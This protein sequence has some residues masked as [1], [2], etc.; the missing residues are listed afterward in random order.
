MNGTWVK[1]T[2]LCFWM[3]F[4]SQALHF[5]ILPVQFEAMR[6][7]PAWRACGSSLF[8]IICMVVNAALV[9]CMSA[10][11]PDTTNMFVGIFVFSILLFALISWQTVNARRP[12]CDTIRATKC[13]RP[14]SHTHHNSENV[15]EVMRST[16]LFFK[17]KVSRMEY[18]R[19]YG[20]LTSIQ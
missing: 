18:V 16:C 20:R 1:K 2:V 8:W 19:C 15:T 13:A 3:I 4:Y 9:T 7:R 11:T 6:P 17:S 5:G 14:C 10:R 12:M